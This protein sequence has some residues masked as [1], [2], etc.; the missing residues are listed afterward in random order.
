M[1]NATPSAWS[2]VA[3]N[4][5][6]HARNV[7]HTDAGAQAAG[8]PAALVAGVTTYAYLTHPVAAAWGVDWLARGG[9]EIRFR[10]PVFA[11]DEVVCTPAPTSDGSRV[12][13]ICPAQ[14]RNPRAVFA[15][16]R[17]GGAPPAARQGERLPERELRLDG[18]LGS[19]YGERAGDDLDL[20][21]RER[22][23]HPAVWPAIANLVFAADLVRGPWIH[24]RSIVRHHGLAPAGAVVVVRS[25]VVERFERGGERAVADITIEHD[26]R[27]VATLEHEAIVRLPG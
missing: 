23:V 26:G 7:I 22:L 15:A 10:A 9:G 12:E 2:V 1:T 4:L 27:P 3:R 21:A 24:T 25:V 13:A 6:E 18:L 14:E 8:F 5:P 11:G 20:Y 16:S 17:V 19:D